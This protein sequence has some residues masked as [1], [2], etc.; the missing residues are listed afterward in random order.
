MK[1]VAVGRHGRGRQHTATHCNTLQHTATHSKNFN[2]LQYTAMHCNTLQYTAI[3]C[4]T[5]QHTEGSEVVWWFMC[6]FTL[7][8]SRTGLRLIT[9]DLRAS[10]YAREFV[11]FALAAQTLVPSLCLSSENPNLRLRSRLELWSRS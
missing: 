4:N 10:S 7:T 11:R 2:T 8:A 6:T 1:C 9:H 3:H 5:L